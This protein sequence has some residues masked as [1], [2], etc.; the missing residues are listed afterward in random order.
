MQGQEHQTSP[1]AVQ[2]DSSNQYQLRRCGRHLEAAAPQ[3][4]ESAGERGRVLLS[5]AP[6]AKEVAPAHLAELHVPLQRRPPNMCQALPADCILLSL[7]AA[8]AADD[9]D[10]T[11]DL[12]SSGHSG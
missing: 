9:H 1:A 7:S 2:A 6:G 3:P 5:K 4:A 8:S 11:D 12:L 10:C